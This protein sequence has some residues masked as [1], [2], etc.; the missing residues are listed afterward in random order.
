[1]KIKIPKCNLSS[2]RSALVQ[3]NWPSITCTLSGSVT[4]SGRPVLSGLVGCDGLSSSWSEIRL[5]KSGSSCPS[6]PEKLSVS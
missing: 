6:S 3:V 2:L 5:V 4:K 1:M